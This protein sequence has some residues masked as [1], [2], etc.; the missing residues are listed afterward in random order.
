[1][2]SV[3][4]FWDQFCTGRPPGKKS[5]PLEYNNISFFCFLTELRYYIKTGPPADEVS[6][7]VNKTLSMFKEYPE[8]ERP[9][10]MDIYFEAMVILIRMERASV[11]SEGEGCLLID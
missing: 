3:D 4:L 8:E 2:A 5:T 9:R 10:A 11:S 7:R 1:M 6:N